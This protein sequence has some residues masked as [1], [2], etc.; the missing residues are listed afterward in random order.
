MYTVYSSVFKN[1]LMFLFRKKIQNFSD[2]NRFIEIFIILLIIVSI[3]L[4]IAEMQ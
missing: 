4:T 3:G 2:H 1:S